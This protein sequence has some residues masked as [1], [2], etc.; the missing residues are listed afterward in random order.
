MQTTANLQHLFGNT[1]FSLLHNLRYHNQDFNLRAFQD[2][3]AHILGEGI[4]YGGARYLRVL[5][6]CVTCSTS[7]VWRIEIRGGA[8]IFD[9]L[10]TPDLNTSLG[11]PKFLVF[12][13]VTISCTRIFMNLL[14]TCHSYDGSLIHANA[15]IVLYHQFVPRRELTHCCIICS[16]STAS[17]ASALTLHRTYS[18][19]CITDL[20][21]HAL[22]FLRP[23]FVPH[24]Y[25]RP[26]Q[27]VILP[28][29]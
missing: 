4:S 19:C 28:T 15:D 17:L 22:L 16:S 26:T 20:M 25:R 11:R 8:Q 2:K 12:P 21:I 29:E 10:Y 3:G 13:D 5:T 9:N 24:I 27:Q 14:A 6:Q 7:P 18:V 1:L 23:Q